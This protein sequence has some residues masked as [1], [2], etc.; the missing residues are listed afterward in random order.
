MGKIAGGSGCVYVFAGSLNSRIRI[1][2]KIEARDKIWYLNLVD[3][4]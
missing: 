2:R 1:Q 4:I 3:D